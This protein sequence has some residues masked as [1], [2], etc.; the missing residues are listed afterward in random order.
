MFRWS[1][2]VRGE[3]GVP[4][5]AGF[6]SSGSGSRPVRRFSFRHLARPEDPRSRRVVLRRRPGLQGGAPRWGS[7]SWNRRLRTG[8][9]GRWKALP[10][11]PFL[12]PESRHAW[13]TAGPPPTGGRGRPEANRP[14]GAGPGGPSPPACEHAQAQENPED[15]LPGS[16]GPQV[17]VEVTE[18][19]P[20][21]E[22]LQGSP[23]VQQPTEFF[24]PG[25]IYLRSPGC[26][27][28]NHEFDSNCHCSCTTIPG[29]SQREERG[30]P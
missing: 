8:G 25:W 2:G 30:E 24:E 19:E 14:V 17:P 12:P 26:S 1:R 28:L 10:E 18:P 9:S 23:P 29:A 20:D 6:G 3:R 27:R 22:D 16:H 7:P 13:R 4:V 15:D 21:D 5:R 11:S